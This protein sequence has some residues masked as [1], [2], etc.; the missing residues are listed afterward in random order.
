[1]DLQATFYDQAS[2]YRH[3]VL[4]DA[5]EL[6]GFV[7]R[8]EAL[9]RSVLGRDAEAAVAALSA[10]LAITPQDVYGPGSRMPKR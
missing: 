4:A 3:V 9:M 10:H 6:D 7:E 5:Q 1:M 8:H 2:R